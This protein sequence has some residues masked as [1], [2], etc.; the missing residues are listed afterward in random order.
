MLM[1]ITSTSLQLIQFSSV[2]QSCP[3]LCNPKRCSTPGFLII[4]NSQ[5]LLK[6]MSHELVMPSNHLLLCYPLLLLLSIFP[7]IRVFAS[8]SVCLIRWPKYLCFILK[9]KNS[10]SMTGFVVARI[11]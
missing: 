4:T 9:G 5:S 2:A 7:S 3:T 8:E 10:V 11:G 1:Q 6:R